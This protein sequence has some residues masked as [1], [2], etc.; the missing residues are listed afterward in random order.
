VCRVDRRRVGWGTARAENAQRKPTQSHISP[1]I[2]VYED[3]SRADLRRVG[4]GAQRRE[5]GA[6]LGA[7]GRVVLSVSEN[8]APSDLLDPSRKFWIWSAPPFRIFSILLEFA[9]GRTCDALESVHR[10]AS[11]VP[12]SGRKVGLCSAS[13]KTKRGGGSSVA[14]PPSCRESILLES[15]RF[16]MEGHS[17]S[18]TF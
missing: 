7:R 8:E 12:G 18:R 4:V 9:R 3:F 14:T 15:R 13:A 10:V 5:H 16:E 17:K 2:R 11:T 6:G 1:S